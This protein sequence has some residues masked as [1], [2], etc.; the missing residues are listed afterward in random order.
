MRRDIGKARE[1]AGRLR[2]DTWYD[3]VEDLLSDQYVDA[4]YI[5]TPPGLHKE[6]AL[7]ACAARKPTYI[8]K[9][10]ARNLHESQLIAGAFDQAG[11]P[12]YVAH[13]R[14]ALPRFRELRRLIQKGIIGEVQ[15]VTVQLTRRYQDDAQ[16]PWL[17]KPEISGGG[18]FF[19]IAP[20]TLDLLV[21]LFG[22]FTEV[23][24]I[25]R[26]TDSGAGL[27]DIVSMCFST[28]KMIGAAV[29]NMVADSKSDA[30]TISGSEG[31]VYASVHGNDPIRI[32]NTSGEHSI[33]LDN[34]AYIQEPMVAEVV[35][36]ILGEESSPCFAKD[37][38]ETYRIID[39][40]LSSFYGGRD[41]DFWNRPGTWPRL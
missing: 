6:H 29:F 41:D 3:T 26:A 11:V 30:F 21:F 14:R 17:F 19:D 39:S 35:R 36:N 1:S 16:H 37:A 31:H 7:A 4:V 40:V 20:H 12:L 2:A 18:K 10:F 25:A 33:N 32:E 28:Q 5:A 24:G 8:E 27:E 9:P 15:D 23:H 22:N 34:P 13:Y 38:L